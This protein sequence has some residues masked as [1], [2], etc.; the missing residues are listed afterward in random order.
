MRTPLQTS[1]HLPP[2]FLS[3]ND[4]GQLSPP[5]PPPFRLFWICV[6]RLLAPFLSDFPG[7]LLGV[8]LSAPSDPFLYPPLLV[9][10][11]TGLLVLNGAFRV[12]VSSQPTRRLANFLFCRP[13]CEGTV[14]FLSPLSLVFLSILN[15]VILPCNFF[16]LFFYVRFLSGLFG[17]TWLFLMDLG[18]RSPPGIFFFWF[19]FGVLF[20]FYLMETQ[21]VFFL[22]DSG[23]FFC[24]FF[25]ILNSFR[26]NISIP[27]FLRSVVP[28]F[29]FF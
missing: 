5:P 3:D 29:L 14:F 9:V 26:H 27:P 20:L 6:R 2:I 18:W 13:S 28:I 7:D 17:P 24:H 8:P 21:W 15:F 4:P 19:V 16:F 10:F 25:E 22:Y 23:V 11:N 12:K 1:C